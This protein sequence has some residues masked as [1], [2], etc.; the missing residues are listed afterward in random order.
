[1]CLRSVVRK[2]D[3]ERKFLGQF[4]IKQQGPL[5]D[6]RHD[7]VAKKNHVIRVMPLSIQVFKNVRISVLVCDEFIARSLNGINYPINKVKCR[8]VFL[9]A[10]AGVKENKRSWRHPFELACSLSDTTGCELFEQ[11][12]GMIGKSDVWNEKMG[13]PIDFRTIVLTAI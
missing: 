13:S 1:L 7:R 6:P 8:D 9:S 3:I 12:I 4:P 11:R 10:Q 5:K 2:S